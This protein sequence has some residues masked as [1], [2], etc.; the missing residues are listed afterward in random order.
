MFINNKG[1]YMKL[2][3]PSHKFPSLSL[4]LS[5]VTKKTIEE[6]GSS[7]EGVKP[8]PPMDRGEEVRKLEEARLRKEKEEA[9][10]LRR[11]EEEKELKRQEEERREEENN[12]LVIVSTP[13]I[14]DDGEGGY[15]RVSFSGGDGSPFKFEETS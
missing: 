5:G 10:E 8:H 13:N 2:R 7:D 9:E 4:F 14:T 3:F 6:V 11:Q 1:G 15:T 12:G